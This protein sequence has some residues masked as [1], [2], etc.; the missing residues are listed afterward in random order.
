MT[1]VATAA[2]VLIRST[3][4]LITKGLK[5]TKEEAYKKILLSSYQITIN[6]NDTFYYAC[7]DSEEIDG[8]DIEEI[9]PIFQKYGDD[10]LI[11]YV[12]VK[13][14]HDPEIEN[15][16]TEDFKSAKQELQRL[17]NDGKILHDI[18]LDD[19]NATNEIKEFGGLT[20]E[21]STFRKPAKDQPGWYQVWNKMVLSNGL[22]SIGRSIND[23]KTR[24]KRKLARIKK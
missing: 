13:R 18:H 6:L 12:A 23:T 5:M 16:I 20:Y 11:A 24:M 19:L 2:M 22:I 17:F 15:H 4:D 14:G 7:A 3:K 9:L 21:W 1:L 10:T 8:D